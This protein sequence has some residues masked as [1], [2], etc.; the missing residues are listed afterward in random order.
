MRGN[1]G[2]TS[3][4]EV[5]EPQSGEP[6]PS[7]QIRRAMPGY[8][9]AMRQGIVAGRE[10]TAADDARAPK[11][12][13]VNEAWVRRYF[14]GRDVLGRRIRLDSHRGGEWRTIVGVVGDARERG[15]AQPAPPVYYFAAAQMPP[16][17]MTLVVRGDV[18]PAAL[19]DT[20]SRID[21]SQ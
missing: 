17:Q 21:V 13:L 16:D 18:S 12:A 14:P 8:F 11:V 1:F 7:N 10:F 9:A 20:L 5:Y 2:P 4:I 3:F 15:L 6:Q 19:H